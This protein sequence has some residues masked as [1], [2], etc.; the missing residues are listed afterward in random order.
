MNLRLLQ[1]QR[2]GDAVTG[3]TLGR[4]FE[5]LVEHNLTTFAATRAVTA[6]AFVRWVCGRDKQEMIVSLETRDLCVYLS[7]SNIFTTKFDNW[8]VSRHPFR[9]RSPVP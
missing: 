3:A 6:S 1:L 9:T 7:E 2:A 4:V 5:P 8:R